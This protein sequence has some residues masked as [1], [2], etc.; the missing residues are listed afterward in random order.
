[1]YNGDHNPPHFHVNYSGQK[2]TVDIKSL[3]ILKGSLS[4]RAENLVLDW[5]EIN[6]S[7]LL[8]NWKRVEKGLPLEK[9]KPLE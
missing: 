8:E 2:A 5:A 9:I 1:M 3:K 7:A 4:R 6:Q